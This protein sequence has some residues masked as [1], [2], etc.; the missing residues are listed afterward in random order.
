MVKIKRFSEND[1]KI[2]ESLALLI[3]GVVLGSIF[4]PS[5]I[6]YCKHSFTKMTMEYK[7][8]PTG[9][10][11][12]VPYVK[13]DKTEN[14]EFQQ[15]RCKFT[16]KIFWGVSVVQSKS[17]SFGPA[18]TN[19]QYFVFDEDG[20]NKIKSELSQGKFPTDKSVQNWSRTPGY[21]HLKD[22]K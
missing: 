17:S 3:G 22:L 5:L 18:A 20:Y 21:A 9:A 14:I 4:L 6:T 11:E 19:E 7:F 8:K 10:T 12:L 13:P 2:N 16:N 1:D 15:L